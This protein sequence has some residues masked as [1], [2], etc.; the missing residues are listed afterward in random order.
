MVVIAERYGAKPSVVIWNGI[1][2]RRMTDAFNEGVRG[3]L[4]ALAHRDVEHQLRVA[5]NR[6]ERVAV[7]KVLIVLGPHT[8]LLLANETPKLVAFHVAHFD[9]ADLLGHDA[10]ALLARQHQQ[11]ENRSVMDVGNALHGRNAV[12]FEQELQNHFGLLDGQ[13]HAVKRLIAGIREYLAAL[14]ALIALAVPRLPNLRHSVRQLWQVIVNLLEIHSQNADNE[15]AGRF[16]FGC[17][18][19]SPGR[20]CSLN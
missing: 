20:G 17:G 1:A 15:V 11:L 18:D 8:L 10:F 13:I 14:V 19:Y 12:A 16:G 4:I 5:F 7:A 3:A 9:V 6:N 2:R